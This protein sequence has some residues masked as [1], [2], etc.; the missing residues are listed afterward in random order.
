MI[1]G[2]V[3]PASL[4]ILLIEDEG[5]S[6]LCW[7]IDRSPS[8]PMQGFSTCLPLISKTRFIEAGGKINRFF[9]SGN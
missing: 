2:V 3:T 8:F 6:S 1:I 5:C 9:V 4:G 7:T